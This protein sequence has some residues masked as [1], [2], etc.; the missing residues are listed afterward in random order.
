[1]ITHVSKPQRA[2]RAKINTSYPAQEGGCPCTEVTF[3][4]QSGAL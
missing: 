3:A 2:K 1:L 4:P